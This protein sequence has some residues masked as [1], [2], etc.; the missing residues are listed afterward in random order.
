MNNPVFGKLI[1]NVG[2]KAETEISLL[3]KTIM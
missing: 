1:F 3:I 2:W